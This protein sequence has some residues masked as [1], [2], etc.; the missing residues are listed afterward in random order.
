MN[1]MNKKRNKVHNM[2]TIQVI[3]LCVAMEELLYPMER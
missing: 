3:K 1:T 2:H